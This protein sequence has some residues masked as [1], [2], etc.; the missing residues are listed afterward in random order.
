MY[1]YLKKDAIK[2]IQKLNVH[3]I[4]C[5]KYIEISSPVV[6]AMSKIHKH[7]RKKNECDRRSENT[8]DKEIIRTD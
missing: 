4:Q 6:Y 8:L 7:F 5:Q 2:K 1:F 3:F